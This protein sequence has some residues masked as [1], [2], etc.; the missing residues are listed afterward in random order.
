LCIIPEED[1]IIHG[2][3]WRI[4]QCKYTAQIALAV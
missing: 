4:S 1:I 2:Q 3:W